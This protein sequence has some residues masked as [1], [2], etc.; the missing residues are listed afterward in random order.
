MN[1]TPDTRI[2]AAL[3]EDDRAFLDSLEAERGM[4][5]QIGDTWKGP[6]GNWAKLLFG[7]TVVMSVLFLIVLWQLAHSTDNVAMHTLWAIMGLALLIMLG[8]AK[9]WMFNR[10]NMLTILREVKRVQLEVV[11]LREEL[12][13]RDQE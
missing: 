13:E 7:F 9:E 1:D 2:T 12:A 3:S 11:A 10:M 8:F 4:F 5:Q 6:M